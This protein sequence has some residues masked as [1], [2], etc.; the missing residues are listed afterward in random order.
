MMLPWNSE[1]FFV[2]EKISGFQGIVILECVLI[3]KQ[4]DI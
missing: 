3:C 1:V 2:S 4:F